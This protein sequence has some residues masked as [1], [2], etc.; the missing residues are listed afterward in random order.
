[1]A[2]T[3]LNCIMKGVSF[4]MKMTIGSYGGIR[5]LSTTSRGITTRGRRV[6]KQKGGILNLPALWRLVAYMFNNS[7]PGLF[8]L[9]FS[10]LLISCVF[11]REGD[12]TSLAIEVSSTQLDRH[13][14]VAHILYQ[15]HIYR[16]MLRV[17]RGGYHKY[18]A[19]QTLGRFDAC[20]G[21]AHFGG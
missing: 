2:H 8:L 21:F 13:L 4:N 17:A 16:L 7:I 11:N 9:G 1:M 5:C 20:S 14:D 19:P 18:S 15:I 10:R 3:A 12:F 6:I